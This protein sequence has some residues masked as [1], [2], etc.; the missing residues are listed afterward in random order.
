MSRETNIAAT[1]RLL[2]EGFTAGDLT[3]C[4]ELVAPDALEHQRGA[5]PGVEGVRDTIRTLHDWF[6]DFKLKTIDL[7]AT[8]DTVWTL[9]R[10]SGLNTGSVFGRPPT[11]RRFEIT[12]IDIVR[13]ADGRIVEHWGVPDQLGMLMQLG[14]FGR[15]QEPVSV[16]VRRRSPE[17]PSAY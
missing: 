7:V 6:S 10:G 14:L 13:F 16:A 11:G 15:P 8:D 4:D 3:V 9:N 1:R 12:V 2:D 5:K 17:L